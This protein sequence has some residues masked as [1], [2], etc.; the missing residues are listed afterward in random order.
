MYCA[1]LKLIPGY[2]EY[3]I[4]HTSD[5]R[6]DL[7]NIDSLQKFW[8]HYP[9]G[10]NTANFLQWGACMRC[11][12]LAE[13]NYDEAVNMRKYGQL[14]PPPVDLTKI[15]SVPVALL[16]GKYDMFSPVEDSEWIKSQVNP[17]FFKI[18]D[19][20]GHITF[21]IGKDMSY[22]NDV[23]KLIKEYSTK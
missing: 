13:R 11:E 22:L 10:S 1:L 5:T 20:H 21:Q 7:S 19:T 16:C 14:E 23:Q 2:G 8:Y 18:Y 3:Y 6:G 12:Y 9:K 17:A 15:H 4:S